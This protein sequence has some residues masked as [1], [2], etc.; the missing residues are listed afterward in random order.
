LTRIALSLVAF[1]VEEIAVL[2][3]KT[4]FSM[5]P[6]KVVIRMI[7]RQEKEAAKAERSGAK[8]LVKRLEVRA[9]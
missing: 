4:R 5:V 6:L 1:S 3:A 9:I 2:K 7:E 8:V